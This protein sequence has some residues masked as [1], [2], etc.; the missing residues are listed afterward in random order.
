MQTVVADAQYPGQV[1]ESKIASG[2]YKLSTEVDLT[3]NLI[4]E[5]LTR[6]RIYPLR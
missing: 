5:P 1:I 2:E 6:Q 4:K 3:P